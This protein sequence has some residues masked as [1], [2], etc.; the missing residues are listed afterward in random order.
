VLCKKYISEAS[1]FD[2][3]HNFVFF[4]DHNPLDSY[5]KGFTVNDT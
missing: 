3:I 5:N 2:K 1:T 4:F